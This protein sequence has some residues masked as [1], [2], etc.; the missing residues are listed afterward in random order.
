ME[1]SFS[2][3]LIRSLSLENEYFSVRENIYKRKKKKKKKG[4]KK[5][6]KKEKKE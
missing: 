3:N 6:K 2:P 5:G 4:K 1:Y